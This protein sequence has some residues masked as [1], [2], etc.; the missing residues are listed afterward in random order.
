MTESICQLETEE[1]GRTICCVH[2]CE[3]QPCFDILRALSLQ[4]SIQWNN[5]L[6][7]HF[8]M[9]LVP[10]VERA[11]A[12]S[13]ARADW[14]NTFHF[15]TL[16]SPELLSAPPPPLSAAASTTSCGSDGVIDGA[17]GVRIR[18]LLAMDAEA[19]NEAWTFRSAHSL[20]IVRSLIGPSQPPARCPP[21]PAP[22]RPA[23][24]PAR[25][26]RI[27]GLQGS[28]QAAPATFHIRGP[29]RVR[30]PRLDQICGSDGLSAEADTRPH[31]RAT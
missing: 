12:L 25:R 31:G 11:A 17:R 26:R 3:E 22:L 21:I 29:A 13:G 23:C 7:P 10:A 20:P 4:G 15:L 5:L 6:F 8:Q 16:E 19:V 24:A 30:S 2:A 1:I 9:E 27:R 28:E 14:K 18:R